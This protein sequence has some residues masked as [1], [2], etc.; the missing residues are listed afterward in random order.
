MADRYQGRPVPADDDHDRR[1]DQ[2]APEK[3]ESDPLAE[4]ARLIGQTDPFA[5]MGR[6]NHQVQPR[7]AQPREVQPRAAERD[8]YQQPVA[9]DDAAAAG[10]PPWMQRA[11]RQ[12]VPQRAEVP[13]RQ[14]AAHRQDVPPQDDPEDYRGGLHP[15]HRYATPR[16]TPE[17]NY[18]EAP[19]FAAAEPEP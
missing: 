15:L 6:A 7:E 14:E 5:G 2:R 18:H 13:Q 17:P 9:A 3:P 19:P 8:Q 1:G 16:A 12:E 10:P 4:L 11:N